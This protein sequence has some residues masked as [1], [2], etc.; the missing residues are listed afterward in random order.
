MAKKILFGKEGRKE[1]KVGIDAVGDTIKPTIGPRGRN[2]IFD[3]GYG[4]PVI[5]GDG[6]SISRE[7]VLEDPIQNIGANLEK[8]AAQR[9]NDT[10]GDGRK[11]TILLTQAIATEGM[12]LLTPSIIKKVFR[13]LTLKPFRVNAIGVKSG[14]D[15]ASKIAIDFLKSIATPITSDEGIDKVAIISSKSEEIGKFIAGTISK[16]GKD[17]VITVEESNVVGITSEI[18]QG[19]EFDKGFISPYF[20]TDTIRQE[21][22]LKES[23]ILVTDLK[24]GAIEPLVPLMEAFMNSGKRDLLIVAEDVVGEALQTF[25]MNK[26]RGVMSVVCVKAPGFGNRKRDYLEDIAI[27]TGATL[28]SQ[29]LVSIENAGLEH[30]GTANRIVVKKDKTTIVGGKGNEESIKGRIESIREEVER[31]ESKHDK[32]KLEERMGKLSGG[33]AVIKIGA[34][35]ETETKYLKLKVED[36]I[37]SVKAALEEGIVPGGGSSLIRASQ[38]ILE[39]KKMGNYTSDELL[40]FD[41]LAKAMEAPLRNIAINCGF[42]DGTSVVSD[43]KSMHAG[44]GFDALNNIYVE[45]M[46]ESGII[47]PLKVERCAVEN[48]SSEGGMFLTT[49]VVM[50]EKPKNIV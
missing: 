44:G 39:A 16:L 11:T 24:I 2:V 49:E 31:T 18:S 8:E 36:A 15:K 32:L 1:L 20:A 43:V 25:I 21:T 13:L 47:D 35:T 50:A 23:S 28:I 42:G 5:T 34:A 27:L 4:G 29:D 12:K 26:L 41:I 48:A 17:S 22:E 45:N 40:G 10:A 9:T 38:A 19:L 3:K 37:N 14:I 46:I 33:I 7:I 30:L 6:G